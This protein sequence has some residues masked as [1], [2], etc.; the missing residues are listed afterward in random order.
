MP[1]DFSP[2]ICSLS[3]GNFLFIVFAIGK[4]QEMSAVNMGALTGSIGLR[5]R[6][7]PVSKL[8]TTPL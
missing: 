3:F 8:L 4:A 5:V 2:P 7:I 1:F 6:Y